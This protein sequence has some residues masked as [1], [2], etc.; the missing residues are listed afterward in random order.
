MAMT[1][2]FAMFMLM[3]MIILVV[4]MML[5]SMSMRTACMTSVLN[6]CMQY[7]HD[8]KIAAKTEEGS[9]EHIQW[10]L[11]NRLVD[12]SLGCLYNKFKC[13]KPY[14]GDIY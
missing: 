4:M 12:D 13:D 14:D 1:A 6:I 5:E 9:Q 11:H 3:L 10:V 2:L 8:I 7:F